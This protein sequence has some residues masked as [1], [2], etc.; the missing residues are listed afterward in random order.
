[1]DKLQIRSFQPGD[2]PAAGM[3]LRPLGEVAPPAG[4][5][6]AGPLGLQCREREEEAVLLGMGL[7]RV[8]KQAGEVV[9]P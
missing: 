3:P 6:H 2:L 9:A 5:L 7:A 8:P 4:D 1:M